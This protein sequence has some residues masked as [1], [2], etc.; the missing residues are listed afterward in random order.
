MSPDTQNHTLPLVVMGILVVLGVAAWGLL[1]YRKRQLQDAIEG[2]FKDFR[3]K[4]VALMDQL[5]AL[6]HRHRTLPSTDPDFTAPMSGA[7]LALYNT[8]EA[9]LNGLWD[10][11]LEVMELWDQAQKL[12]RSGSGLAVKQAEEA[13]KLLNKG[14]IDDLLRQSGSCKERLDRLN[15][16]HEKAREALEAGREEL[17]VLRKAI[18]EGSGGL[19]RSSPQ[20]ESIERTE[21]AF[22]QAEGMIVADPIGAEEIIARSR[23]SLVDLAHRPRQEPD[24]PAQEAASVLFPARRAR[25]GRRAVSHGCSQ[26]PFDEPHGRV[27]TVLDDRLGVCSPDRPPGSPYAAH[28]FFV[29]FRFHPGRVLGNLSITKGASLTLVRQGEMSEPGRKTPPPQGSAAGGQPLDSG[30]DSGP[31][32]TSP[33]AEGAR[34]NIGPILARTVRHFFP[35]LNAWVDE[36][37]DPRFAPLVIYHKRFLVWWGLSLFLCKL[38]SRRQLDYQLNTDGPEVLANLNRLAETAQTSRPVNQTL[39]YF[40]G[41]TGAAPI[42]GLRQ[43][44]VQRLIRMKALDAARLQGRFVVLIDASGYL[45]FHSPHCQQCLTQ[46]HGE[47]T[48][49]M[50]QVLEAK[51]LGPAGTVVSIATEFIDNRDARSTPAGSMPGADQAGLRAEGPAASVGQVACG[52]PAAPRLPQRRRAVCLRGRLPGRQ[53]LSM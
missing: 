27:R 36:F 1:Y 52:V 50:H 19:P 33:A 7:T 9:D 3:E 2:R 16:G 11:W 28:R 53:G 30:P 46:R 5:D 22:A 18:D 49:Y 21:T 45:V 32:A 39:E 15:Q 48:L 42:A 40:L 8:V 4:A 12:V 13:R 29:G 35:D 24:R 51:L 25:R 10:H 14:D 47:T 6:R 23:R 17:A 37:P 43:R 41:G 34:L 31:R 44:M 38:S 20:Q 26:A